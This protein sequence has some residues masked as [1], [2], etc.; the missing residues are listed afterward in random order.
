MTKSL[1]LLP[2]EQCVPIDCSSWGYKFATCPVPGADVITRMNVA[3]KYSKSACNYG[4]S[5]GKGQGTIWVNKGC[6]AKF[7]VCYET[8]RYLISQR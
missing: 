6:R 8:G 4:T 3:R 5:Y 2:A 1:L 7:N